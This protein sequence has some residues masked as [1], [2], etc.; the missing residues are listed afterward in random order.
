MILLLTLFSFS[1]FVGGKQC[2]QNFINASTYTSANSY[3]CKYIS[4]PFLCSLDK[5]NLKVKIT[6]LYPLRWFEPAMPIYRKM[7]LLPK[8]SS[9]DCLRSGYFYSSGSVSVKYNGPS[10]GDW[11]WRTSESPLLNFILWL[12]SHGSSL[13]PRDFFISS[14]NKNKRKRLHVFLISEARINNLDFINSLIKY[15][16]STYH[17][18]I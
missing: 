5:Y 1:F 7:F 12:C 8:E 3:K 17:F 4:K 2:F 18:P 15:L 6:I 9:W 13:S 14:V 16:L 10:F 11:F